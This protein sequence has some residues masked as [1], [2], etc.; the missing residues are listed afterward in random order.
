MGDIAGSAQQVH[1]TRA[2]GAPAN[3]N[4]LAIGGRAD[5]STPST[6]ADGEVVNAWLDPVG[7]LQ[8]TATDGADAALGATTDAAATG[9]GSLIA[10]VKQ[11][12]AILTDVWDDTIN[13]F[14]VQISDGTSTATVRNL[15][16]NDA[17]NVAIVDGSGNQITSFGGSSPPST[18]TRSS[19]SA[20]TS[21]T[22]LLAS[23]ASRKGAT[24]VNDSVARMCLALG[25]SA[26]LTDYTELLDPRGYYEVPAG[27]T[28]IITGIWAYATG[29]ARVTELT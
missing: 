4:P 16:A 18:A 27:Y 12:R 2:E 21:N 3:D 24:I 25:S 17:L 19:V 20:A 9:N 8:T 22:T 26:S 5:S 6:V 7:R 23:N 10:I 29:A 15:A 13:L 11:L 14:R 28:G 1:G